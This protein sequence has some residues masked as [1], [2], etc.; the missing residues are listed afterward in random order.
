MNDQAPIQGISR[1]MSRAVLALAILCAFTASGA[2]VVGNSSSKPRVIATQDGEI[3][4]KSSMV[5]FLMYSSDYDVVGIVENNSIFQKRG[6]SKEQWLQKQ[7]DLYAQVYPNLMKHHPD[8]PTPEHLK[9]V[10]R[11]GNEN[12]ADLQVGPDWTPVEPANMATK[13]TPGSDLIIQTLLDDDPRP[14]HVPSWGGAN[15]TAYALWKIKT[16]MPDKWERAASRIRIYAICYNLT[17]KA[18]D[19]GIPWIIKNLPEVKI[20]QSAAWSRTW[21]YSSVGKGS[22]SPA[23]VQAFM[24]G[25]WLT[26]NVK[27]G[28]GPLGACYPQKYVSEGDT[29]CFLP[30]INN[31]LNQHLDYTL[32]GWGGR[33][34]VQSGNYLVDA[35]DDAPAHPEHK[36]F[37]RWIP[38]AQNDF[39]ARMDW[40]LAANFAGANHNPVAT[41]AGTLVRTVAPGETVTL[42]ASPS[43]DPDG[44]Q[45]TFK[46]WQYCEADP[47]ENRVTI[48]NAN[49]KTASFVVPNEPG[50]QL[51]I[52]LEVTDDGAPPLTHYQRVI[53]DIK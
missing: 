49:A 33:A 42:D 16:T 7:I 20:Y 6:H 31:G 48:T 28:H 40:C 26:N 39:A 41:V 25:E 45:I 3:D 47:A 5:R 29:P 13:D 32:G 36:A 18:Q 34:K 46:W 11:L 43:T 22:Y 24:T 9:S 50:K 51:H 4:D 30:L 1:A 27:T 52:I 12:P 44:N 14:V 37:W 53:C 10:I 19:G 38:A 15:T 2:P 21:N 17:N 35:A 23:E 8:Y